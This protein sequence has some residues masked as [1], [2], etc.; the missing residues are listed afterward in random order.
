LLRAVAR[1]RPDVP[2]R[3]PAARDPEA[4]AQAAALDRFRTFNLD[5]AVSALELIERVEPLLPAIEAPALILQGS[6]DTVV[7]PARAAWLRDRLGSRAR[8][9]VMLPR[10]DHLAALDRD[11]NRLIAEVLTFLDEVAD[12]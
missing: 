6:L 7:E 10:S 2:R 11:R 12:A 3:R 9:L 5:A 4:R 8:R 1:F